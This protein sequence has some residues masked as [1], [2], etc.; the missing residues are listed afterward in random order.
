MATRT[1]HESN[2]EAAR[3]ARACPCG[4]T[5][6]S[7]ILSGE[8]GEELRPLYHCRDCGRYSDGMGPV[9]DVPCHA[10]GEVSGYYA[11][12]PETPCEPLCPS[13]ARI[14]AEEQSEDDADDWGATHDRDGNVL[15][16]QPVLD[17]LLDDRESAYSA[18]RDARESEAP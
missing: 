3:P 13:C 5:N 18:E 9:G 4:S 10:C 1:R 17:G 2:R 6:L 16:D 7:G 11:D 12:E 14:A 8:P 15:V